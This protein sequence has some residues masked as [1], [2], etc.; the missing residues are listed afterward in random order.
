MIRSYR[1]D[2]TLKSMSQNSHFERGFCPSHVGR[3]LRPATDDQA[4]YGC[5]LPQIIGCEASLKR[6]PIMA[7]MEIALIA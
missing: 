7:G 5:P 3:R 6:F 4:Q 1:A 2:I